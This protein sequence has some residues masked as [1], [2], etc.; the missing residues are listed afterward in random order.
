MAKDS[1]RS[2]KVINKGAPFGGFYLLTYIGAAVYFVQHSAGFWAIVLA[3][4]KA[5]V[6]P[7]IVL[8]QVLVL[9]KV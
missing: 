8:H 6:W 1:S 2:V 5:A 7:A 3:L 4:L 9:L